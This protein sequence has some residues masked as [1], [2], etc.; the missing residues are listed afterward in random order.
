MRI[1]GTFDRAGH[2]TPIGPTFIIL[3]GS[4]GNYRPRRI[5]VA[6]CD[7]GEVLTYDVT[8]LHEY[9]VCGPG[10]PLKRQKQPGPTGRPLYNTWNSIRYR[11]FNPK[12][13]AYKRYG[14]RGIGMCAEWRVSFEAFES[15]AM[16]N[17]WEPH[18]EI[19]RRENDGDYTPANCRFVTS[20]VNNRNRSSNR[21][22]E[23][24][25]ERKVLAEWAE[26]K[27]C[28]V[29]VSVLAD[30]VR[31]GWPVEDAVTTPLLATGAKRKVKVT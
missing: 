13:P 3:R 22:I 10:C 12:C 9:S 11:C 6:Q 16:E 1:E 24:F 25:G 7:C 31:S 5:C 27:R 17:G 28:V 4:P 19:D 23:A 18:L 21:L 20:R 8:R 14:G 29:R 15:W 26:D 2:I 30:R